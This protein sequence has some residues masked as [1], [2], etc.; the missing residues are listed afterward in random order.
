LALNEEFNKYI[1]IYSRYGASGTGASYWILISRH[2]VDIM[3]ME[4][5]IGMNSSCHNES[6]IHFKSVVEETYVGA[7]V[8]YLISD[9]DYN[10]LQD[11]GIDLQMDEIFLDD[12][13]DIKGIIP[14]SRTRMRIMTNKNTDTTLFMPYEKTYGGAEMGLNWLPAVYKIAMEMQGDA[15]ESVFGTRD[16]ENIKT[17]DLSDFDIYGGYYDDQKTW[18]EVFRKVFP[19]AKIIGDEIHTKTP[20]IEDVTDYLPEMRMKLNSELKNKI[21]SHVDTLLYRVN[22][23][24]V[25]RKRQ[26]HQVRA[27]I[28]VF[29]NIHKIIQNNFPG[30]DITLQK[31]LTYRN[32]DDYKKLLGIEKFHWAVVRG[33]VAARL[34]PLFWDSN[35]QTGIKDNWLMLLCHST[36]EVGHNLVLGN[37][38][39]ISTAFA[40][41]FS[42]YVNDIFD[43]DMDELEMTGLFN[44]KREKKW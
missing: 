17:I 13:R 1:N 40:E 12:C 41:V 8:V 37:L 15:L 14:L 22:D 9:S 43:I 35:N 18:G 29:I 3:R 34:L 42:D 6:G 20:T 27:E 11:M 30:Q 39:E 5:H 16:Y 19:S 31:K 38:E 4:D 24:T 7:P 10:S 25:E 44:I 36:V 33:K 2:P 26:E 28:E 21:P 32:Y 23:L